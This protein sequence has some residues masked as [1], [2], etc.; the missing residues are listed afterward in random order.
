MPANRFCKCFSTEYMIVSC[1]RAAPPPFC[2]RSPLVSSVLGQASLTRESRLG[3][4]APPLF[5]AGAHGERC[6][7]V[8]Q[9]HAVR[10]FGEP[11]GS[12]SGWT[13]SHLSTQKHDAARLPAADPA[14]ATSTRISVTCTRKVS[15]P[16]CVLFV[17]GRFRYSSGCVIRGRRRREDCGDEMLLHRRRQER[18]LQG[19]RPMTAF[20]P[21]P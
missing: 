5:A 8:R 11:Q 17:S 20:Q 18:S 1:Q 21:R 9:V 15:S 7:C 16:G 6:G 10:A 3:P 19:K 13:G 4:P 14:P 2:G 12:S